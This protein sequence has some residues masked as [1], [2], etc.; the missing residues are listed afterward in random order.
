G[1]EPGQGN[2]IT[3][4]VG[5]GIRVSGGGVRDPGAEAS[6]AILG[7]TLGANEDGGVVAAGARNVDNGGETGEPG[8]GAGGDI[9]DGGRRA[10]GN[11]VYGVP[12]PTSSDDPD[13]NQFLG[14]GVD[15]SGSGT[16]IWNNFIG[17]DGS[18]A[19]G[20]LHGVVLRGVDARVHENLISGNG[21]SGV[22]V[23]SP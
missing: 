8:T 4:S 19:M 9:D 1:E 17:T 6:L 20:L 12:S 18:S 14:F 5:A 22:S 21:G 15:D 13:D 11:V 23:R 16:L 10:P 7:N 3:R 2:T